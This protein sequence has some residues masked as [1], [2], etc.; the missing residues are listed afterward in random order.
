MV[1]LAQVAGGYGRT[2]AASATQSPSG[3]LRREHLDE[4]DRC[5]APRRRRRGRCKRPG[6][7]APT[8]AR[9]AGPRRRPRPHRAAEHDVPAQDSAKRPRDRGEAER[10]SALIV[11]ERNAPSNARAPR[12]RGQ[13]LLGST[14]PSTSEEAAPADERRR[15]IEEGRRGRDVEGDQRR[16]RHRDDRP[17]D[18][19]GA[20][21]R[22][23]GRRDDAADARFAEDVMR[24][25][26]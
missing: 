9:S 21:A 4:A 16:Q 5:T 17:R 2:M 26:P 14:V 3:T 24:V 11:S 15:L 25:S 7:P 6:T 18:E 8:R 13:A 19:H 1:R 12:A 20:G 22:G 23:V 10:A